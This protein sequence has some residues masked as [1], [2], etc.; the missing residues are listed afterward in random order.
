MHIN[1]TSLNEG[2]NTL[3][4]DQVTTSG[5]YKV[6]E[7]R[8]KWLVCNLQP[9]RTAILFNE[10]VNMAR[11]TYSATRRGDFGLQVASLIV[12]TIAL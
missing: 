7:T 3:K 6:F 9:I 4:M 8:V 10:I 2:N 5:T 11:T 1:H 12:K